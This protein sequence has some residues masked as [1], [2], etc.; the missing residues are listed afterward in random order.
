MR[1][2]VDGV[3][4]VDSVAIARIT[5]ILTKLIDALCRTS[6]TRT[7]LAK[8]IAAQFVLDLSFLQSR[9]DIREK[10]LCVFVYPARRMNKPNKWVMA[11]GLAV[12]IFA[13][14]E[15]CQSSKVPPVRR[16]GISAKPFSESAG[17]GC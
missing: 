3:S 10:F 8:P 12:L 16:T 6:R 2:C 4:E 11:S 1:K 14:G 13:V 7:I 5:R 9:L 15:A 17:R